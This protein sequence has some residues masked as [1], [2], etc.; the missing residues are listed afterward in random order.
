MAIS[1]YLT[2]RRIRQWAGGRSFERGEA[3][4]EEGLV[5]A[6]RERNTDQ[7]SQRLMSSHSPLSNGG[8]AQR[9]YPRCIATIPA[10]R[11]KYSQ[12]SNPACCII[13][14]RVSWSGCIRIDSAR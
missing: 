13:C 1:D 5:S 3:Y 8:D 7:K 4:F 11:L 10:V 14:L 2:T 6:L 12:R 9:L